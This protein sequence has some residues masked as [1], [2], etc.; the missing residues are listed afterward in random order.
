MKLRLDI[1]G[2]RSLAVIAVLIFHINSKYLAGGF[3]GVDIFFV[4]SGFLMT[5][6]LLNDYYTNNKINLIKF[7][8]SRIKRIVPALFVA[9]LITL[10][11]S[12]LIFSK[13]DIQKTSNNIYS[14]FLFISNI[15]FSNQ[16]F[17]YWDKQIYTSPFLH[18][19]SLSVEW[20]YYLIY[21]LILMIVINVFKK[22]NIINKMI[23]KQQNH[24]KNI[25]ITIYFKKNIT[26]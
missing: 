5:N 4:I 24:K 10:F 19:W 26:M 23:L 14:S 22:F 6:I 12:L 18:T 17:N 3:L 8:F 1:Q 20:Q 16:T 7:Y 25:T 2:L 9:L 21:P 11:L 15:F 13:E